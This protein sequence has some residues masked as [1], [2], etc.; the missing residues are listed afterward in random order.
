M[1]ALLIGGILLGVLYALV[2]LVEIKY[3]LKIL[4]RKFDK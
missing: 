2:I 1:E 4:H 3:L